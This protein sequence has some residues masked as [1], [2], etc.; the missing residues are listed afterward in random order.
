[1]KNGFDNLIDQF[2]ADAA[3][4]DREAPRRKKRKRPE[5]KVQKAIIQWL[6][7]RGVIVAVTD[8]GLLHKFGVPAGCGIPT[9]W[10]DLTCCLPCG[11]FLGVECKAPGEKQ[12]EAQKIFQRAFEKN[13]GLYIVAS[14]VEELA[15]AIRKELILGNPTGLSLDVL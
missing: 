5:A 8:A 14:S 3:E 4:A 12:T 15:L 13:L 9:G 10:P 7:S 11:R 6:I 1:M 2:K